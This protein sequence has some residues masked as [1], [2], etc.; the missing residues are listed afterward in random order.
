DRSSPEQLAPSEQLAPG[1]FGRFAQGAGAGPSLLT[2]SNSSQ[3]AVVR[4]SKSGDVYLTGSDR[5]A[6]TDRFPKPFI[7]KVSIRTS[8]KTRIFEGKGDMLETIDAV[9]SDDIEHV[10]TT[11]QKTDV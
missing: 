9:D 3:A 10:F 7:D 8:Q 1:G 11:R 2:R 5:A 6:G 4:V